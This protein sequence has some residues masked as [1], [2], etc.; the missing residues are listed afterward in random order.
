[1]HA[2]ILQLPGDL[3]VVDTSILERIKLGLRLQEMILHG[4]AHPA[5]IAP[6]TSIIGSDSKAMH[7][8]IARSRVS[9]ERMMTFSTSPTLDFVQFWER[10]RG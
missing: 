9:R 3:V 5:M 1:L 10:Q 6:P 7:V 4:E 2:L 8:L